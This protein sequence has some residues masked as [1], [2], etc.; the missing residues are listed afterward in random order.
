MK[1][2]DSYS[3]GTFGTIH[4]KLIMDSRVILFYII[5]NIIIAIYV[6]TIIVIIFVILNFTNIQR[7]FLHFLTQYITLFVYYCFNEISYVV[8]GF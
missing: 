8:V 2:Y 4:V 6:I 5:L 3:E 1:Y 7:F